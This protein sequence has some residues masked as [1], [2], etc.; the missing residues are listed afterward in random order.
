MHCKKAVSK[1]MVLVI[2]RNRGVLET[3]GLRGRASIKEARTGFQEPGRPQFH[4][5]PKRI[6]PG[7]VEEEN[8][9]YFEKKMKV[10]W[11]LQNILVEIKMGKKCISIPSY[12]GV[13]T[14]LPYC[15]LEYSFW[16][17]KHGF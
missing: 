2:Q 7:I 11:N 10:N 14:Q 4:T 17:M 3:P 5:D 16:E 8:T 13:K 6:F 1:P 12:N 15:S 9:T